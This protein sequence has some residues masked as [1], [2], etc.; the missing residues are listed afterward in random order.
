MPEVT[1]TRNQWGYWSSSKKKVFL[2]RENFPANNFTVS[3]LLDEGVNI[4]SCVTGFVAE[5][6][7]AVAYTCNGT[8]AECAV[9]TDYDGG[10]A[11]G[12]TSSCTNDD[13]YHYGYNKTVLLIVVWSTLLGLFQCSIIWCICACCGMCCTRTPEDDN[14]EDKSKKKGKCF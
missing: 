13:G 3:I 10:V 1:A 12:V 14:D 5:V 6:K 8:E 2:F 4:R 11:R 9:T 7:V